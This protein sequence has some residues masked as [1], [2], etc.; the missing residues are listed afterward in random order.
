MAAEASRRLQE[1]VDRADGAVLLLHDAATTETA[2]AVQGPSLVRTADP[3]SLPAPQTWAAVLV[4]VADAGSL[5][6]LVSVLPR[7]GGTRLVACWLEEAA[8][9]PLLT[10]RPEWPPLVEVD[11]RRLPSG[12]CL[13][14]LQFSRGLQP[15]APLAEMARGAAPGGPRGHQGLVVAT[16]SP[17]PLAAAPVDAGVQVHTL[18]ERYGAPDDHLPSDVVLGASPALA[19]E[20]PVTG[21]DPVVV[22]D[23][24]LLDGPLD[25]GLLNPRGFQEKSTGKVIDLAKL[26]V[27]PERGATAALVARLRKHAGVRVSWTD[28]PDVPL[29]RTVAGFAMAGVPVVSGPVPGHARAALGDRLADLVAADVDLGIGLDRREHAVRQWRAALLEHSTLGWRRRLAASA[30]L[31]FR[32]FPSTSV[33]LVT[34]RPESLAF[35]L[36]QV[37]RQRE[38]LELVVVGHGF[39]PDAGLVRE[40]V[41]D[42]VVGSAPATE[43]YGNALNLAAQLASGDLLAKMD[44]DDWYGR[45]FLGDVQLARYYSGADIVGTTAE[46]V[47]LEEIDRTVRRTDSSEC[48]GRFVAGGTMLFSRGFLTSVGGF[49][50]VLR[51][52]DLQ[53]LEGARAAGGAIYRAHGLGYVLR[54]SVGGHTWQA[55]TD[56]FLD[57][58]RVDGQ[59]EGFRPSSLLE[60]DPAD[61]PR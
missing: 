13:T 8:Q 18:D 40:H 50:P 42:A 47:Y 57:P 58:D 44:D 38:D 36:R 49:R 55:G 48:S 6:R 24:L 7:V 35:A 32:P 10:A 17:S 26:N 12:G 52:V 31:P 4:A 51:S 43:R 20:K 37:A 22:S 53:L 29:A 28:T 1:L 23:P 59:W 2:A 41:P 61:L 34:R 45:D 30:G 27:D 11:G 25:E 56:Y 39:E 46:F 33:L 15:V 60:L 16:T 9:P 54:R 3:A 19:F 14:V 21:R 5:R